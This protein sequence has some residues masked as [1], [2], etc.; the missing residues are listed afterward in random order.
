MKYFVKICGLTS[1]AEV[2]AVAALSPDAIGFVFWPGSKRFVHAEDV[3]VWTRDLPPTI[4]KVGVFV[5]SEALDV[6]R[7][8]ELA[9]LDIA[10]LHGSEQPADF[11]NFPR[12]LWRA[13]RLAPHHPAVPPD[14]WSVEAFLV[15]AYSPKAPGG[16]GQL[17]DWTVAR[18]FVTHSLKPVILAGGLT[19]ENVREA[20]KSVN[21][22]GADVSSGVEAEP[23][24]KDM[25][26]VKRFIE[27]C[28]AE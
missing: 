6:L 23:G 24:R 4:K 20:L 9:N 11:L 14:R 27:Q 21:P 28:R 1:E 7:T 2:E 12:P 8:M 17:T 5:D 3:A 25:E 18:H 15:D 16:T 13:V 19:P 26:K 10:Q 22:W